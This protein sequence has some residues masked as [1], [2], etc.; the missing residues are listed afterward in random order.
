[1]KSDDDELI[2]T[3]ASLLERLKNWSDQ[4]SWQEFF[5]TYWKL[6][7]GVARKSGLTDAEAQDVVQNTMVSIAKQMPDFKLDPKIGSFK[8][9]LLQIT[10]WRILDETRK[11][12]PQS[13]VPVSPGD[14]EVATDTIAQVVDPAQGL[15]NMWET[16]WQKSLMGAAIANVKRRVEPLDYQLFDIYVNKEWSPQKVAER[17]NVSI[18]R[19]FSVKHRIARMIKEELIRLERK[20]I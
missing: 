3:R 14:Q 5:E 2:P 8:S 13:I 17:F 12:G 20:F 7:Y 15:D 9:W 18:S 4:S 16:E 19:V 10:K 6:I 11:R 1:M